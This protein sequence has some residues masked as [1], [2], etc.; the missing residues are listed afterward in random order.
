MDWA[1]YSGTRLKM[2]RTEFWFWLNL[3]KQI[4]LSGLLNLNLHNLSDQWCNKINQLKLLIQVVFLAISPKLSNANRIRTRPETQPCRSKLLRLIKKHCLESA[5]LFAVDSIAQKHWTV[6]SS[7]P[8]M[9]QSIKNLRW[10]NQTTFWRKSLRRKKR[11]RTSRSRSRKLSWMGRWRTLASNSKISKRS[12]I[13]WTPTN[14]AKRKYTY[15]TTDLK[16]SVWSYFAKFF[17]NHN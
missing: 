12:L 6:R 13:I 3:F 14:L 10:P 5:S 7:T 1:Q 16:I 17:Q 8:I 2:V 11:I 4:Y 9:T 15:T